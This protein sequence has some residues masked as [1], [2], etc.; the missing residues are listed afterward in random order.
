MSNI[1]AY[2]WC[3]PTAIKDV[4]QILL[5]PKDDRRHKQTPIA[6]GPLELC[7]SISRYPGCVEVVI[8]CY[9]KEKWHAVIDTTTP[10]LTLVKVSPNRSLTEDRVRRCGFPIIFRRFLS[11]QKRTGAMSQTTWRS[12]SP[13]AVFRII[14]AVHTRPKPERRARISQANPAIPS[15][16]I[17]AQS[18]PS[19]SS[20]S[21][22]S[23]PPFR[24][25]TTT[26]CAPP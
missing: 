12:K 4:L 21:S 1:M 13:R 2:S 14:H 23:H 5:E 8:P 17:V 20:R 18:S 6:W 10:T 15:D 3:G 9:N 22:S 16:I 7:R 25:C 19:R 24:L 11:V 26:F